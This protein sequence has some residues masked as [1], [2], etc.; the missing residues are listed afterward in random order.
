MIAETDHVILYVSERENEFMMLLR[1]KMSVP[2]LLQTHFGFFYLNGQQKIEALIIRFFQAG[3][4]TQGGETLID[5]ALAGL[6]MAR[7]NLVWLAWKNSGINLVDARFMVRCCFKRCSVCLGATNTLDVLKLRQAI[8]RL[9]SINW[10]T[11]TLDVLKCDITFELE[12]WSDG[13]RTH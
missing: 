13:Q 10:A 12:I 3:L 5:S 1:S 4:Y 6:F 9:P 2:L 8:T 11:N 7:W